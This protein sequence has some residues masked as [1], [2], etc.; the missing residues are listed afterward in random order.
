MRISQ[1][2]G[3]LLTCAALLC[4]CGCSRSSQVSV[5]DGATGNTTITTTT[6]TFSN[7]VAGVSVGFAG[8]MPSLGLTF[9]NG[10]LVE[11]VRT[12]TRD[13]CVEPARTVAR[14]A[15]PCNAEIIEPARSLAVRRL[16]DV[17]VGLAGVRALVEGTGGLRG[18]TG[19]TI[20]STRT[21]AREV[22]RSARDL[23]EEEKETYR[24]L[25]EIHEAEKQRL[26]VIANATN[27]SMF[28]QLRRALGGSAC[29]VPVVL[30]VGTAAAV[31]VTT[32]T[33][34]QVG[35]VVLPNVDGTFNVPGVT[36]A[37]DGSFSI[38]P[39][40]AAP[41]TKALSNLEARVGVLEANQKQD[42]DAI[43]RMDG[44]LN[45]VDANMAKILEKLGSK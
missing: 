24:A 30:P 32:T 45:R 41:Q 11:P 3:R 40:A 20:V 36:L 16:A 5:V 22:H 28:G 25:K 8:G 26:T 39:S 15:D 44:V 9:K 35:D 1:L 4:L 27:P 23:R 18:L 12:V 19:G 7:P 33:A 2:V 14:A 34:P 37:P 10:R 17:N 38:P 31:A 6:D 13:L 29:A 43:A 21:I 42:H